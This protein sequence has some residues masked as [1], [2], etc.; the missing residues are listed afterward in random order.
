MCQLHCIW[1]PKTVTWI[2]APCELFSKDDGRTPL[3]FAV[4]NGDLKMVQLLLEAGASCDQP[5]ADVATPLHF[6]AQRGVT[7]KW[8]AC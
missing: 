7:W 3:H 5:M 4:E 8:R 6:A 1:Q 2:E